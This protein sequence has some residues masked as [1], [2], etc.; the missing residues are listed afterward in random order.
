MVSPLRLGQ[1]R[2][3]QRC[4]GSNVIEIH[5]TLA[6]EG[7]TPHKLIGQTAS[8]KRKV[9]GRHINVKARQEVPAA[10]TDPT[11]KGGE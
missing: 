3:R 9:A 4:R 5:K 6:R 2:F 1:S 8:S 11:L 10:K 7:R